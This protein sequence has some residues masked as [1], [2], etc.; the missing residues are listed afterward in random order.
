LLGLASHGGG[1]CIRIL[2]MLV[3]GW[4]CKTRW[5]Y[6]GDFASELVLDLALLDCLWRMLLN[7]L[8]Q[9]FDTHL[10]WSCRRCTS[11]R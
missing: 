4:V 6:N 7:E 3:S 10:G 5:T 8:V 2:N 1:V 9:V 11:M